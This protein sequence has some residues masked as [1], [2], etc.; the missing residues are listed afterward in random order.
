[1][2]DAAAGSKVA[3]RGTAVA[4]TL[5]RG[6]ACFFGTFSLA[7]AL[8]AIRT[9]RAEDLW[10]IDLGG[11]PSWLSVALWLAAGL[12]VAYAVAPRMAPWRRN[13]TAIVSVLLAFAG[14]WNTA[15]FYLAWQSGTFTPAVPVP[16]TAVVAVGFFFVGHVAFRGP[17]V[18]RTSRSEVAGVVACVLLLAVAFPLAHVYFFG[19]T[20]YR[21]PA[22]VAVVFG[23]KAYA[24]GALSQSLEDRVRTSAELYNDGLVE[25]LVMSG[26]VGE[27]GADEA[28]AMATR[29][30]ALGV[31]AGAITL[32]H[33]GDNT[34]LTVANTTAMF[35]ADGTRS[36]LVVSQFYHLPRIKMAYRAAGWNVYTVPATEARPII[37]TPVLVAR[38]IPGFWVYWARAWARDLFGTQAAYA[39]AGGSGAVASASRG[40]IAPTAVGPANGAAIAPTA[41]SPAMEHA[42]DISSA[43]LIALEASTP[44]GVY[45][46]YT[47]PDGTWEYSIPRRWVAGFLPGM[48]WYQY[49]RT[50]DPAWVALARTRQAPLAPYATDT[51]THDLGFM[52]QCSYGND[53]RLTDSAVARQTLL[54]AARSLATRYDRVVGMVR[55]LNTP[56]DF[57]VYNDTMVNIELLYWGARNGG[58]PA[59]KAMATSH[60]LRAMKD[61]TRADGGT[62]H[63]VAYDEATGA[64]LDKGQAQGYADESTWSRGQ[65][66]TIYGLA[67]AFRETD[68]ASFLDGVHA[69]T[70]Y[71]AANTPE[72]LVPYW[73]FDAPGI[74][75]EPRDSSAAAAAAVAFQELAMLDPD[76]GRR[77]QYAA[78]ASDTLESLSSPAYLDADESTQTAT[79]LHGTYFAARGLADHGTS[80]GDYYFASALTRAAARVTRIAGPDRYTTAVRASRAA[81]ASAE[82]VVLAS[83]QAYPDALA[84]SG[85]AGAL[86]APLLLTPSRA[87]HPAVAAEIARLGAHEV[88]VAGGER[89]VSEAVVAGLRASGLSVRRIAGADRYA[90]AALVA[91]ETVATRGSAPDDVLV[92]SGEG[93]ADA[94]SAA[95]LA[96]AGGIPVLLATAGGLPPATAAALESLDASRAIIVGGIRAV[97]P[98]AEVAVGSRADD[99]LRIAGSDRYA[100]SAA[101]AA[102]A[103]DSGLA[104]P[105]LACVCSGTAFPDALAAG[106]VA[107]SARGVTLLTNGRA[108][109]P[110][111]RPLLETYGPSVRV[112]G[113]ESVV[114]GFVQ[115]SMEWALTRE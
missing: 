63:Y 62:Y 103:Y 27:S 112:L 53:F 93:Y 92:A 48:L 28:E 17:E 105:A 49:E 39:A 54:T 13:A 90:T 91:A 65:A 7:N 101:L 36:V 61:F 83:G 109:S 68:D 89:A 55:T 21:R 22:E 42:R 84:A 15:A 33:E 110:V 35:A 9:G 66:W 45:P 111:L 64:V 58:D 94:V 4:R 52:L 51:G 81:F 71:W 46:L 37:K 18:E 44:A 106:T 97:S 87:A 16:F 8:V 98:E 10:W 57:W 76:P 40:A 100:T 56:E 78:L 14:L 114:S 26:G 2:P 11:L 25:R 3:R 23:A 95:P 82:S 99:V 34:D 41:L 29:A 72:D 59:W 6:V 102:W 67:V 104:D 85:L 113:G 79:L 31:P 50:H 80:W 32:D 74:P 73:D 96:Y 12:L 5:A 77:A 108:L 38:E 47:L 75:D 1:M 115:S 69:V 43:N 30:R 24:S 88:I 20:D 70:D 19:T 107:G 60:A 86:D